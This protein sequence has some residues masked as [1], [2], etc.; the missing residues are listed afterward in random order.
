MTCRDDH[1]CGETPC[2]CRP[3][4]TA[5]LDTAIAQ[6]K[7]E[8]LDDIREGRVPRDVASF[9]ELHDHVD[10][11]EYGGLCDERSDFD[12]DFANAMQTAVDEWIKGGM[13]R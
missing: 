10:A 5:D 3:D 12:L 13:Q 6:A 2:V 11:N 9:T 8:I 1:G 4:M 7:T